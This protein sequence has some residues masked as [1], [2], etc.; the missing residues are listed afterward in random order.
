[1]SQKMRYPEILEIARAEGKVT[2]DGLAARLSVTP[3]TIRRDLAD[4]ANSGQLE[5]VHGGAVLPSGTTNIAYQDRRHLNRA[6]KQ[7]IGRACA[8]MIPSGAS[9]FLNI[10]TTTEAVA[11]ALAGH[12]ELM[13][14]TNNINVATILAGHP[15]CD[16]HMTG[17]ALRKSDWG[18]VG[19]QA[20]ASVRRFRFDV[21]VIGCSALDLSGDLLDFDLQ[22]VGVSQ[23]M[24]E[25]ARTRIL[26]ADAAKLRRTAPARIANLVDLDAVVTDQPLLGSL[27]ALCEAHQTKVVVATM[28]SQ[29]PLIA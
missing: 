27:Q 25:N 29:S 13:V 3:Q 20:A 1:M 2:V 14:V 22:E 21:A 19:D 16:V 5:R 15:S 4:L 8:R 11:E 6:A 17:G 12:T 23:A 10:G 7:A 24:L 26:V 18:L 28:G 9:I